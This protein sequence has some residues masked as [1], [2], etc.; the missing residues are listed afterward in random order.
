MDYGRE[1][2]VQGES[3]EPEAVLEALRRVRGRLGPAAL[4]LVDAGAFVD[5]VYRFSKEPWGGAR[6]LAAKGQRGE[7]RAGAKSAAGERAGSSWAIRRQHAS[8]VD[9]VEHASDAG[10]QRI[11][12]GW[13]AAPGAIGALDLPHGE[14]LEYVQHL[15]AER[16]EERLVPGRG[17]QVVWRQLRANHWLDCAVLSALGAEI[18]GLGAG[19]R[20]VPLAEVGWAEKFQGE[21]P[22]WAGVF[23]GV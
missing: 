3:V 4:V 20:A 1:A 19:A 9:L 12:D 11:A 2:V 7:W 8:Y 14:H 16:R 15:T 17:V 21:S 6:V 23:N 10:K 18:L 22:P 13:R 5:Q